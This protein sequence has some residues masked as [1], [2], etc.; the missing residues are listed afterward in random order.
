[1]PR[2]EQ[3]RGVEP[4]RRFP[5]RVAHACGDVRRAHNLQAAISRCD[6][7][8]LPCGDFT[9]RSW[10]GRVSDISLTSVFRSS[11]D[12]F[13][14]PTIIFV[15]HISCLCKEHVNLAVLFS[16]MGTSAGLMGPL[17][18]NQNRLLLI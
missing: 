12:I 6:A 2:F 3:H 9:N 15:H 7:R 4:I 8:S 11:P 14:V 18:D 13:R 1:M 5:P 10:K 16:R 17:N